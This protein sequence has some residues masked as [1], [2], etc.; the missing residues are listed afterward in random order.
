MFARTGS[1]HRS[2]VRSPTANR[3]HRSA[4]ATNKSL[5]ASSDFIDIDWGKYTARAGPFPGRPK[6]MTVSIYSSVWQW[7]AKTKADWQQQH[8]AMPTQ[9]AHEN[10]Q[11]DDMG[12][13]V[14]EEFQDVKEELQY[15]KF[16]VQDVK[17][18]RQ[19]NKGK[20]FQHE[21]AKQKKTPNG[22]TSHPEQKANLELLNRKNFN[23]RD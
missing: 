5:I 6:T 2:A 4:I 10:G 19:E 12:E 23:M 14:K 16:E 20:P 17:A 15:G 3:S 8:W 13:D 18:E 1:R 9:D 11:V 21:M 22:R 7:V